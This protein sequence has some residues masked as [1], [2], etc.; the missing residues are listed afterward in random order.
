MNDWDSLG[1]RHKLYEGDC[2][3]ALATLGVGSVDCVLTDP[4]YGTASGDGVSRVSK[5]GR[6]FESFNLEWDRTFP[7]DWIQP[8]VDALKP[9]GS[10]FC[11]IDTKRVTDLWA[12]CQKAGLRPLQVFVWVK[13]NPVPHPRKNFQS[14]V[15][16][17][18][19]ARKPGPVCWYG[20]ATTPNTFTTCS[21]RGPRHPCEKPLKLIRRLVSVMSAPGDTL[22][23]PFGGSGTLLEACGSTRTCY[24]VERDPAFANV[25][26]ERWRVQSSQMNLI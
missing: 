3:D 25:I 18:V 26:R 23:D 7:T 13:P 2:H 11:F 15:E 8:S 21:P 4:P 10:W 5:R 24:I 17:A 19:Y 9:G 20:G 1:P 16:M 12:L 22:L 6:V 14:A